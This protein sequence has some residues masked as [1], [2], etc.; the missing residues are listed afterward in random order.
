MKIIKSESN[1]GYG[2]GNNLGVKYAKGKYIVILNPDTIVEDNWLY[3]IIK[4]LEVDGKLIT[5]P[6][7]LSYDGS[8]LSSC[9]S[10]I[11][12]TG[13]A[14]PIGFGKNP[15]EY[16]SIMEVNG[17]SGCCFAIKKEYY[18]EIGGFDERIFM[19]HDDIDFS[20]N[21]RVSGFKILFIPNAIIRHD[22]AL[23][24]DANKIYLL[25]KGRYLILKKY[26]RPVQRLI[27]LPSLIISE[28]LTLGYSLKFGLTGI[29]KKYQ[30]LFNVL[31]IEDRTEK[32]VNDISLFNYTLP[33]DNQLNSGF[34]KLFIIFANMGFKLNIH[35]GRI[36]Y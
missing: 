22:Y 20:I 4:P 19:Y 32:K 16:N 26:Y 35:I 23:R 25:E 5:I 10:N 13:L 1:K 6:K 24:V 18:F 29:Y 14:F 30:G 36:F 28:F 27:L 15:N 33:T 34:I 12:Y 2:A 7:I 3:E 8:K 9:G 31:R 21:V 17:I 11:H